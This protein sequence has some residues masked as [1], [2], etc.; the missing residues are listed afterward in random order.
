[1]LVFDYRLI[2]LFIFLSE[3]DQNKSHLGGDTE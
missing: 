2:V 1:M 3:N